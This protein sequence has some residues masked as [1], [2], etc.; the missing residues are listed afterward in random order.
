MNWIKL[1]FSFC[2]MVGVLG[3]MVTHA[4]L[5]TNLEAADEVVYQ[6]RLLRILVD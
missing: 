6:L 1:V 5:T 4:D 2:M 3:G